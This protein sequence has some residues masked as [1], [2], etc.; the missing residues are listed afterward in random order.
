[1]SDER[2]TT[3]W[4]ES[5]SPV[6]GLSEALVALSATGA[7]EGELA[8]LQAALA[9]QLAQPTTSATGSTAAAAKSWLSFVHVRPWLSVVLI[10]FGLATM[11]RVVEQRAP[12]TEQAATPT[13]SPMVPQEVRANAVVKVA[14]PVINAQPATPAPAAA[15]PSAR[16]AIKRAASAPQPEPPRPTLSAEAELELL[17][18]AQSALNHSASGALAL[19]DEHAQ[20][21]PEGIFAQEREMLR[22]EAELKL[23]KREQALIRANDFSQ[24]FARSTYRARI[25]K[26]LATHRALKNRE[27]ELPER[28]NDHLFSR[29]MSMRAITKARPF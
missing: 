23:G 6:A 17:R 4:R 28:T 9:P 16:V 11:W 24:R 10:G 20:L 15:A 22:I 14:T 13:R 7:S 29:S 25:E 3:R 21:Y 8:K 12:R 19:A 27:G 2:T 5:G 18:K 1:M 26:L